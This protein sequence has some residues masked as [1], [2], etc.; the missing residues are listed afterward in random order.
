MLRSSKN[1]KRS[2]N[3]RWTDLKASNCILVPGGFGVRGVE[4]KILAINYARTHKIPYLGKI[5]D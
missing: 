5:T 1:R 3:N 2:S 4:G